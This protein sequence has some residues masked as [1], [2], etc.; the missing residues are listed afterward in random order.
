MTTIELK[1][2]AYDLLAQIQ[3]F[4]H[5]LAQVNQDIALQSEK[6][7]MADNITVDNKE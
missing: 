5:R 1:A 2:L 6:D 3:S 4:Q 7:K